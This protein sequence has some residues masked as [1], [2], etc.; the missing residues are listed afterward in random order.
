MKALLFGAICAATYWG[1]GYVF[2]YPNGKAF[3]TALV[4]FP[5]CIAAYICGESE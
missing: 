2:G 3:V 5:G 4:V 1:V